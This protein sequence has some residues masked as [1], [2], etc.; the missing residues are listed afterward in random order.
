MHVLGSLIMVM[1]LA[2]NGDLLFNLKDIE[3]SDLTTIRNLDSSEER[4]YL[5]QRH[6]RLFL[7]MWHVAKGMEYLSNMKVVLDNIYINPLF[8]FK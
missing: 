8:H 4:F 3:R 5:I 2:E 6:P 7:Y 1:E